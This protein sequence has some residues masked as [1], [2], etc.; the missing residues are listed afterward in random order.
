LDQRPALLAGTASAL[1]HWLDWMREARA[2]FDLPA[3][4]IIMETGGFKGRSRMLSRAHF[5]RELSKAHGVPLQNILSEYGMT[6]LLSQYYEIVVPWVANADL[7]DRYHVG[8][9]WLRTRVLDPITLEAVPEGEPGLLCHYDLANAGS[10]MAVLTED[11]GVEEK[12]GVRL[13]GRP[14]GAEPRGCSLTMDAFL[15]SKEIR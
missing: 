10:V 15:S 8:P 3:R 14:A 7:Q 13:L 12:G 4:S 6:E 11:L 2:R 5:Y 9:P 1:V